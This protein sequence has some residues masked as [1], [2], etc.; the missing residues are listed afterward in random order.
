[1][2]RPL[3][4]SV[5]SAKARFGELQDLSRSRPQLLPRLLARVSRAFLEPWAVRRLLGLPDELIGE[6]DETDADGLG[7]DEAH[8]LLVAGLAEEALASPEHDREDDEP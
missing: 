2:P 3:A 1:M 6:E 5:Q 8:G 4:A 7:I